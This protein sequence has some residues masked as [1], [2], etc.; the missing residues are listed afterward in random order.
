MGCSPPGSSVHG[1]SQARILEWVAIFNSRGSSWPRDWTHVSCLSCIGRR[2]LYYRTT[3]EELSLPSVFAYIF[4]K[5]QIFFCAESWLQHMGPCCG[6]QASLVAAHKFLWLWHIGSVAPEHAGTWFPDQT[7]DPTHTPCTG[8]WILNHPIREIPFCIISFDP[9]LYSKQGWIFSFDQRDFRDSERR[10]DLTGIRAQLL[11]VL[12]F[13]QPCFDDLDNERF[14]TDLETGFLLWL[15]NHHWTPSTLDYSEA[16]GPGRAPWS[17][18]SSSKP[19][20]YLCLEKVYVR[21]VSFKWAQAAVSSMRP[22][23]TFSPTR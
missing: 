20:S 7:R 11:Y 10:G 9:P 1:I 4:F 12:T 18:P 2:I 13:S 14:K 16:L 22:K 17:M 5:Y 15:K 8:R 23:S 21:H 3:W 19:C 6:T